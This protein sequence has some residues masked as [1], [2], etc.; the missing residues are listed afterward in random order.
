M[1][2]LLPKGA[3]P[4]R[5]EKTITTLRA[6]HEQLDG[7]RA[8]GYAV[9]DEEHERGWR[10]VACA[11]RSKSATLGAIEIKGP[12]TRLTLDRISEIYVSLG[13]AGEE[14]SRSLG[15]DG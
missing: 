5:T 15:Y 6:L 13:S 10:G 8:R 4:A 3:L 11:I 7:V 9:E 2:R 14:F 12:S 1:T